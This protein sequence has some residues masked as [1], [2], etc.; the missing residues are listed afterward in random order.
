M[1]FP[2]FQNRSCP[3]NRRAPVGV[4]HRHLLARRGV[5]AAM[6]ETD[7]PSPDPPLHQ[8]IYDLLRNGNYSID[9]PVVKIIIIPI[10][11]YGIVHPPRY[12]ISDSRVNSPEPQGKGQGPLGME[13]NDVISLFP[14]EPPELGVPSKN[15]VAAGRSEYIPLVEN[16]TAL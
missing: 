10:S 6:D 5:N 15:L 11:P 13:M 8:Q 16:N 2:L 4:R 1:S 3:D 9:L 7:P 14:D 12:Q